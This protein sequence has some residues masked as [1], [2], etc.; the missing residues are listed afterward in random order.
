MKKKVKYVDITFISFIRKSLKN[1]NVLAKSTH[2]FEF[3]KRSCQKHL[4]ATVTEC[5]FCFPQKKNFTKQLDCM[6]LHHFLQLFRGPRRPRYP[7]PPHPI[8]PHRENALNDRAPRSHWEKMVGPLH[9][10]SYSASDSDQ[11]YL[12]YIATYSMYFTRI[13][14]SDSLSRH[15]LFQQAKGLDR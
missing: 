6:K 9:P 1:Y 15:H 5:S 14:A 2:T 8:T 4:V 10:S 3:P 12:Q 11:S 13:E 7:P